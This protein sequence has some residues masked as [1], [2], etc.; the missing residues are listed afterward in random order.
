VEEGGIGSAYFKVLTGEVRSIKPTD[1]E[2]QLHTV[3]RAELVAILAALRG[4]ADQ[5]SHLFVD[6]LTAIHLIAI[7]V[8]QPERLRHSKHRSVLTEIA[9]LLFSK[10]CAMQHTIRIYKVRAHIGV[11]G[12]EQADSAAKAAAAFDTEAGGGGHPAEV[13]L[14]QDPRHSR[15]NMGATW[16]QHM[17]VTNGTGGAAPKIEHHSVD[18]LKKQVT[19]QAVRVYQNRTI[20]RASKGSVT[21][22]RLHALKRTGPGIFPKSISSIWGKSICKRLKET[23]LR[24]RFNAGALAHETCTLCSRGERDSIPHAL[25]GCQHVDTHAMVCAR[26]GACVNAIAACLRDAVNCPVF[27]DAECHQRTPRLPLWLLPLGAQTSTPDLV[28][29]PSLQPDLAE[30]TDASTSKAH[31][32]IL[33]WFHTYDAN[34]LAR[35]EDKAACHADVAARIQGHW[36]QSTVHRGALGIS[37]SGLLPGD[38]RERLMSMDIPAT[39]VD[40]LADKLVRITVRF[41]LRILAMRASRKRALALAGRRNAESGPVGPSAGPLH[42]EE[43]SYPAAVPRGSEMQRSSGTRRP[44]SGSTV[45]RK[46]ARAVARE[47]GD[48]PDSARR[49]TAVLQLAST[50]GGT[51]GGPPPQF[52]PP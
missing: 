34:L 16:V 33:E 21:L 52:Q 26:H 3:L 31:I 18:T 15:A 35:Q 20:H 23:A 41:N 24:I 46:R 50:N 51:G 47:G 43:R 49:R 4:N 1:H 25:G 13:S 39:Q 48:P 37:H 9:Q 2:L 5:E 38:F 7:A 22:Q 40:K 45:G 14:F 12:N 29:V 8:H 10:V 11:H 6:S 32:H 42:A 27:E 36:R 30:S 28:A 17:A 19:A 44:S